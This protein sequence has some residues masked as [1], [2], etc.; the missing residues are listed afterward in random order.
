MKN[1]ILWIYTKKSSFVEKDIQLLSDVYDVDEFSFNNTTGIKL[2]LSAVKQFLYLLIKNKKYKSYVC[3]FGGYQSIL[4]AIFGKVFRI[5]FL[6]ITGG[7]DCVSFPALNYG[8]FRK[9]PLK[10]ITSLSY[11][12]CSHISPVDESLIF[13]NYTYDTQFTNQ[14]IKYFLPNLK[15]PL[16]VIYNGYSKEKWHAISEK[17][18]YS[19]ITVSAGYNQINIYRKGIDLIYEVAEYFPECTFTI[20]G[21]P[22]DF[23]LFPKKDNIITI[24]FTANNELI[25]YYSKSEF[26]LQLS[27]IEGFPNALCEAM[28]CECIPIVSNVAA[29]PKIITN[30][31]FILAKRDVTL[32]KNTIQQ[33]IQCDKSVLSKLARKRIADNYTEEIRKNKLTELIN[34]MIQEKN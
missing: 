1:K 24:P 18:I 32:L 30:S 20:I 15:T 26:Y 34:T 27:I 10:S 14:G 29:M 21:I 4:P 23:N 11:Q 8:N 7:T 25:T 28:L 13:Q 6:I 16:T 2:L 17:K 33:A 19:F 31:G 5:P 3:Q 12:L 22:N 9:Q